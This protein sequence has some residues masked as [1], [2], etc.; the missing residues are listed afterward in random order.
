M[1]AT[2][3]LNFSLKKP[4]ILANGTAPI[5]VR[6]TVEKQRLEFTTKRFILPEKLQG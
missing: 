5:Y 3:C 4:K 2:F 6:L 1:I